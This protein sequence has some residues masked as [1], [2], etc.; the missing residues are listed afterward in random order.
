MGSNDHY[1]DSWQRELLA[2]MGEVKGRM[3]SLEGS[4]KAIGEENQRQTDK[5]D[6]LK[7]Q[8]NGRMKKVEHTAFGDEEAGKIG[9]AEKVRFLEN[10]WAKLTTGA[11]IV[12]TIFIELLK[13]GGRWLLHMTVAA[14]NSG[15]AKPPT[16][17]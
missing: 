11:V 5:I 3:A 8:F 10:G 13:L 17:P 6:E 9:L 16:H 14:I 2:F 7:V 15:A 4:M 1:P 12:V